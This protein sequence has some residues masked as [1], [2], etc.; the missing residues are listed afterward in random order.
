MTDQNSRY[1]GWIQTFTGVE[2]YPADP[3]IEDFSLV[4][5]AHSTALQCR[6]LGHCKWHFSIAQHAVLVSLYLESIGATY[7]EQFEGL[8]HDDNEAYLRDIPSPLKRMEE[9][10]NHRYFEHEMDKLIREWLG[11]PEREHWSEVVRHADMVLLVTEASQLLPHHGWWQVD[12]L[13]EPWDVTLRRMDPQEAA[14][15]YLSRHSDLKFRIL[16]FGGHS[17]QSESAKRY[18]P[19]ITTHIVKAKKERK[20]SDKTTELLTAALHAYNL[21]VEWREQMQASLVKWGPLMN[22]T[23]IAQP[24]AAATALD[25]CAQFLHTYLSPPKSEKDRSGLDVRADLFS[26]LRRYFQ[27]PQWSE[28]SKEWTKRKTVHATEHL[29][30]QLIQKILAAKDREKG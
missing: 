13:P 5:I 17:K 22:G 23:P 2:F 6:W 12:G 29:A 25:A 18:A 3:R 28:D 30:A 24:M 9:Y 4:D 26:G 27:S 1:G 15:A 14:S 19:H 11:L 20:M 10:A 8:H 7:Q 16:E 21:E